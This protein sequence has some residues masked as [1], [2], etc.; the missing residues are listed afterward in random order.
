MRHV[1]ALALPAQ[2][3]QQF[4]RRAAEKE[5][6]AA[7]QIQAVSGLQQLQVQEQA[8]GQI[9]TL[10]GVHAREAQQERPAAATAVHVQPVAEPAA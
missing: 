1:G 3:L 2:L 4:H 6:A 5:G 8:R 7:E 10:R 9:Q